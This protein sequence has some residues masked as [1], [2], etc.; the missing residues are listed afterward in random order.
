MTDRKQTI[1]RIEIVESC[2]WYQDEEGLYET[3]CGHYFEVTSGS[4]T[5]N[6]MK[7]CCYCGQPMVDIPHVEEELNDE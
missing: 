5:E 7:F 4:A 6:R 3:S 2:E 1:P